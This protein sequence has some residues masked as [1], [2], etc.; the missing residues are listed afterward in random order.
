MFGVRGVA[1]NPVRVTDGLGRAG[2][3]IELIQSQ[4]DKGEIAFEAAALVEQPGVNGLADGHVRVVAAEPLQE[5]C[6]IRSL[7][8]ELRETGLVENRDLFPH[9][10]VFGGVVG[11]PVWPAEG[12]VRQGA[13]GNWRVGFL[14]GGS[15][16]RGGSGE[17]V[18][19]F[20]SVF[21]D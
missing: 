12:V 3:N 8:D 21:D 9:G 10:P 17:P 11:K 13:L 5:T 15:L 6:G 2:D 7:Q 16:S 18:R 20:P 14:L 19:T 1:P 4:S